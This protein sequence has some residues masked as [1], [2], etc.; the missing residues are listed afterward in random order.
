MKTHNIFETVFSGKTVLVTGHTGFKGSWLSVWLNM[1]GAKV[2]G[3]G[4]AA[5]TEPSCFELLNISNDIDDRRL[6]IRDRD[7]VESIFS[8]VQ[9]DFVFHLAAQALVRE[10]YRDPVTTM[11]TNVLGTANVLSGLRHVRKPSVAIM[12]TSDKSY[13][14]DEVPWGYR[15]NDVI[16]GKDPYSGSKSACELVIS[17]FCQSFFPRAGLVRIGIGRAGNVV[18]GGDWNAD[19]IVPDCVRAWVSGQQLELRNPNATRPWQHVLEPVSGYMNLAIKLSGSDILHGEA[20]NF[21]PLPTQNCSVKQLVIALSE[22]WGGVSWCE[23]EKEGAKF[24][25]GLLK[26]NCDKALHHL[27][28]RP[29]LSLDE[30][31]EMTVN[32]YKM[33]YSNTDKAKSLMEEQ[34]NQYQKKLATRGAFWAK[35]H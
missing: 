3:L 31:V 21:G 4:L 13:R 18:G 24:E 7:Q 15:E 25:A 6:D 29:V 27:N 20:F 11:E 10:S 30:L 16:G 32:L 19:R 35:N 14:N 23:A 5:N 9:P 33:F 2:V 26:L 34:I 28:W 1:L 12:V 8:E 22:K 17:S